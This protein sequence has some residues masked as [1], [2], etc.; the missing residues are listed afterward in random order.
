MS[1]SLG[2]KIDY[3]SVTVAPALELP[4]DLTA[5][6]YDERYNVA[7]ASA[8]AATRDAARPKTADQIAPIATPDA[9]IV[10]NGN[11]RWLVVKATPEQAWNTIYKFWIDTGF[12]IAV[13][14]PLIG[15]MET[16]WS[17]NRADLP[18]DPIRGMLGK[19]SEILYTTYK[20]DKFRT[21][22][23]RGTE[24][25]TMDVYVTHRGAEQLPTAYSASSPVAFAWTVLPPNPDLEAEIL[26]R[27]LVRFGAAETV[28]R[29][30][31]AQA[32]APAGSGA[33]RVRLVK[34]ADGANAL[35]V[36]DSFSRS[37]RRVGLALDRI[38]FT[39]VDRDRT[40]GVYY[41]RYADPDT[42]KVEPGWWSKLQFW[43][44][45]SEKPEQY[46]I[47]VA[48]GEQKSTVEVRNVEGAPDRS[49]NGEKILSLIRDQLK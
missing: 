16:D 24:P 39:V 32:V 13:D 25:G 3:R 28:A 19:F 29:T 1:T 22:V 10:R 37:W 36:D 26:T 2:K 34:A 7:T 23:E 42:A 40:K 41:V 12:A 6:Q 18:V 46:Q 47:A 45:T 8:V 27:M 11:D 44:D 5:P 31:V 14:Q 15:V 9:R 35:E 21:R 43:K 4:P 20:R 30:A 17:E 48:G 49:A 38:G 33:E